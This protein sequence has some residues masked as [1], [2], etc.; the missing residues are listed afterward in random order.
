MDS[1]AVG[2]IPNAAAAAR[3]NTTG[4]DGG[5]AGSTVDSIAVSTA[6]G[7]GIVGGGAAAVAGGVGSFDGLLVCTW[8]HE[9]IP[10]I[11]INAMA[12]SNSKWC[13]LWKVVRS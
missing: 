9:A 3:G 10:Q 13:S 7:S 11:A 5:G 1:S 2:A 6:D 8:A 4:A 12:R